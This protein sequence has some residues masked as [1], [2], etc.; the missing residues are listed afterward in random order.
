TRMARV[1]AVLFLSREPI[2]T[3][4]ISALANLA[5]GTE[6]RTLIRRLN[7]FYDRQGAVF[8]A[9]EVAGGFQLLSRRKF[10]G[11]LRR[12]VRTPVEARLSAPALG[13]LAVAAQPR[14]GR[15]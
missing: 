5:D 15:R 10:A 6:A 14:P 13:T 1:E 3:R 7:E 9:E 2:H 8:R 4:K 12:L 11:W